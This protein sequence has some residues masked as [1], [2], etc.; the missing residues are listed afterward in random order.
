[1]N[2]QQRRMEMK[3]TSGGAKV[4]N[5]KA[6]KTEPKSTAMSLAAVRQIGQSL[7]F[8]PDALAAGKGYSTPVGPTNMM[9][10]GPGTGR[11]IHECG[12]QQ[13]SKASAPMPA[14][15]GILNK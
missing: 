9:A 13:S 4:V 11:T 1:M 8:K 5:T 2:F 14:A 6:P 3:S 7:A 10:Q 12:S 15:R